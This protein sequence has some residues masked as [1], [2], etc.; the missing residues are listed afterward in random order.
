MQS[1]VQ[2]LK[3]WRSLFSFPQIFEPRFELVP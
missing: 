1:L 3:P 2:T